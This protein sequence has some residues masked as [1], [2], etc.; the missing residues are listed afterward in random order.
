MPFYMELV[1]ALILDAKRKKESKLEKNIVNKYIQ[2]LG[3]HNKKT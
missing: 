2:P 1:G 3:K